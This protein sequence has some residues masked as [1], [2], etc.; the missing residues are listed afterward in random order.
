MEGAEMTDDTMPLAEAI[1]RA[2][3]MF[4]AEANRILEWAERAVAEVAEDRGLDRTAAASIVDAIATRRIAE[5]GER[6]T[7]LV[8]QLRSIARPAP[9]LH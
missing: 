3:F 2:R 1:Q 8:H 9:R 6:T 5:A 7:V 4:E